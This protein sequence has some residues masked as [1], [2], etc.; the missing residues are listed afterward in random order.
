MKDLRLGNCNLNRKIEDIS[1]KDE[2]LGL[3]P[4]TIGDW[5]WFLQSGCII[6]RPQQIRI[7]R[8]TVTVHQSLSYL[9]LYDMASYTCTMKS[10]RNCE[11]WWPRMSGVDTRLTI[12][13]CGCTIWRKRFRPWHSTCGWLLRTWKH[14]KSSIQKLPQFTIEENLVVLMIAVILSDFQS[15]VD[16]LYSKKNVLSSIEWLNFYDLLITDLR[17]QL[18]EYQCKKLLRD[19]SWDG[20]DIRRNKKI[21]DTLSFFT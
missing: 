16:V 21:S 4:H 15:F 11:N 18:R 13:S 5:R 17:V 7:E 2:I 9:R 14:S 1:D 6:Q 8:R 3:G 20:L 10:T 19:K 12:I